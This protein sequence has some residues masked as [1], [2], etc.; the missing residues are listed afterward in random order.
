MPRPEELCES[1][2]RVSRV[3]RLMTTL[4]TLAVPMPDY[5]EHLTAKITQAEMSL[6]KGNKATTLTAFNKA[7]LVAMCTI[8]ELDAH[9]TKPVL[10]ARLVKYVSRL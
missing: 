10:A 4:D 1:C 7:I 2:R 8:R 9:G 3:L 6:R 5:G